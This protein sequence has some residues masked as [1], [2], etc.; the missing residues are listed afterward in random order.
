[1]SLPNQCPS[2]IGEPQASAEA[3]QPQSGQRYWRSVEDFADSPAFQE[4][5]Q[6][7]FPAGASE[8]LTGSRRTFLQLM[9]A[10]MALAGFATIPG[11]RRPDHKIMPY[12]QQVPEE[13]IPG[14][15]L[16]YAT[17][18]PLPGGGAEGLL[19]E[20][21]EGRPTKI[22]GNPLHP[23]NQ[24]KSGLWAQAGILG[25]YD[26]DRLMYPIYAGTAKIDNPNWGA[27][28][29]WATTHFANYD[30]SGGEGLAFMVD[31]KT[32]PS[33]DAMR[34]KIKARWPKAMWIAYDAT[35]SD[36]P[37][38]GSAAAFGSARREMLNVKDARVIVSFD[39]D[40]TALEPRS[41][42][43][44][45]EFA[46]GRK[47]MAAH[48]H[49]NRLYVLE[50]G[51]SLT[52]GQADHRRRA[53]P[54]QV[55]GY[56]V[57]LAKAIL[58]K[59][60]VPGSEALN[61]AVAAMPAPAGI[62]Q[63]FVDELAKDLLAS[64]H[65][66]HSLLLAGPGQSAEIHA[67]VHALNGALGNIG[68]TVSYLAKSEEEAS[69]SV[70]GIVEL[71]KAIAAHRVTTLVAVDVNPVYDAPVDVHFAD[72]YASV[73][74]T[75]SLHVDSNETGAVSTWQLNGA[76]FLESWGDVEAY[77]GTISPV[78]PMIAPLYEG[79]SEI[80]LLAMIAGDENA[81]GH[82]IVRDHWKRA[83]GQSG[84]ERS[85]RRALHDGVLGGSARNAVASTV[86]YDGVAGAVRGYTSPAG[87]G[88]GQLEVVFGVGHLYDGRF[89]NCGWL[90]ELPD[91]GSAVVWDNPALLSPATAERLG[92]TPEPYTEET[93]EGRL[94]KV[95]INGRSMEIAVWIMP[96][97]ADDT[98][99]LPIGF[100]RDVCGLVGGN[101]ESLVGF[102]TYKV[103]DA[104]SRR[105]A[106]GTIE[107]ARGGYPISS[108]QNHWSMES[109]TAIVRQADLPA[110]KKYGD[111]ILKRKDAYY[112]T[113]EMGFA[114]RLGEMAHTP[115][116]QSIYENPYNESLADAAPGSAHAT[117]QQWGMS[118][119]L[120][121]CNGCGVCT[122]ACQAENN[123]PVVGKIETAKGREMAWIR[124]DRYFTGEKL[125]DPVDMVHQPVACHHCENAP[126]ETVCPVNATTHGLEGLN[127]MVYN[128]CIGTRYCANNCPYKVRRFN[129]FDYGVA[130]F[131]GDYVG[132]E[133]MPGGGPK[134]VNL[135]PP[136]LRE[137]LDEITK[138]KMNPDVTVRSRGVMEKCTFCIQRINEARIETK[139]QGL[140]KVPE[141]FFQSACQ[142]ACPSDAIAFGD[143][144]DEST[145]IHEERG[146][147][148]SYMLLG[149]LNTRPRLTYMARVR[150]PNPALITDQQRRDAWEN[151]FHHGSGA[152]HGGGHD[153]SDTHGGGAEETHTFRHDK[154]K[155]NDDQ[156]YALSLRILGLGANV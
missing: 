156:G 42:V 91:P 43:H 53:T 46:A 89:A 86:N 64:D 37:N 18:M 61:R 79:K 35:E 39:R 145:R 5:V 25:M 58:P 125:D 87:A 8:L 144:R 47:V 100:G 74:T 22:E 12:S 50:S 76:H 114:E 138:M 104:A 57:A 78:Q 51:F 14:K 153:E 34:D 29:H 108:T 142:Q 111:E 28:A 116:N 81:D 124:V 118:I 154:N 97:M 73:P 112:Q 103:R 7:E 98:M 68:N 132:K 121:A 2:T 139:V 16:Y 106:I 17:S 20:T 131:N 127:Y 109:R 23:T 62:D 143:I 65:L 66:G 69:S 30:Q 135:I 54:S 21:H 80:E 85:W 147:T 82:E 148:R 150:N 48:D 123:I 27:F 128:R 88:E 70:D 105:T 92:L 49:M 119:D 55:A 33:R 155:A 101:A 60:Q 11:C 67:L 83:Y 13:I 44:A 32:S 31:K 122:V 120:N 137:R 71:S 93:P 134:N 1:M 52:G 15:P 4:F 133:S 146:H 94:A 113:A 99:I 24:G 36:G 90:Q 10:S 9:G 41:L 3:A 26:P 107:R 56:V 136:R 45:R 126:C 19:V 115:V 102:N 130:K 140:S 149:Y 151:P 40:F 75:V 152:E 6:R 95:T 84:F 59:R 141:G 117:G 110:W 77:D 96:G 38:Q 129:F 72:K 63:H